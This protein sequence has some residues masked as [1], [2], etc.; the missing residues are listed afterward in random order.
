MSNG[1]G[2]KHHA[3]F[4]VEWVKSMSRGHGVWSPRNTW[5]GESSSALRPAWVC[6]PVPLPASL[7]WGIHIPH[8]NSERPSHQPL[9]PHSKQRSPPSQAL[10][11]NPLPT[12]WTEPQLM[13]W[14]LCLPPQTH[15][16]QAHRSDDSVTRRGPSPTPAHRPE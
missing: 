10:R 1:R 11:P 4:S 12:L 13:Q 6:E 15:W 16:H 5:E 3:L 2:A 14:R 7:P 9:S 8:H